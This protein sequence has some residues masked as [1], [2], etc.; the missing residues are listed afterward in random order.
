MIAIAPAASAQDQTTDEPTVEPAPADQPP[1]VPV[2]EPTAP[3]P[4]VPQPATAPTRRDNPGLDLGVRLGYARPFGSSFGDTA[5]DDK[6]RDLVSSAVPLALEAGY[7]VNA[8]FTVGAFFQYGV[9][10]VEANPYSGCGPVISCSGYLVR[11]GVEGIYNFNLDFALT[12][13]VGVGA[14]YEWFH[15]S[16]SGNGQSA[17]ITARGFELVTVQAGGDVRVA[18]GFAVGPYVSLSLARYATASFGAPGFA[19]TSTFDGDNGLHEWLQ[20]GV[21]GRFSL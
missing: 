10:Q 12:P 4:V 16:S 11:V 7:R 3:P 1:V 20:L 8:G 17:A 5:G 13:W 2:F 6:L 9:M 18:P 14:G 21:R 19:G 15:I